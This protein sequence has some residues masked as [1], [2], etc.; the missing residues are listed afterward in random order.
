M[1]LY[2]GLIYKGPNIV[3]NIK[4]DLIKILNNKGFKNI[5][6]A[7]GSSSPEL[8]EKIIFFFIDIKLNVMNELPC[9]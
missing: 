5:N 1:Q 6:E 8:F 9:I 4:K 3:K 7:V 2:T